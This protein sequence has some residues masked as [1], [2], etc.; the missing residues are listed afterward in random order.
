MFKGWLRRVPGEAPPASELETIRQYRLTRKLGEGG[1]GVVFEAEDERLGRLVAIKRVRAFTEDPTHRERLVREAR[2]AAGIS[3]PNI[4]QVYELGEEGEE[5]FVVMELLDG[6]TLASRVARGPLPLN[7]ALQVTLGILAALEAMHARGIVHRDLKP[8]NVFLTPHGPK[9]LDFGLAR[10]HSAEGSDLTLTSPG[11]ILGTPRYMAPEMLADEPIGPATDLFALGAILFEMLA[12]RPAF[13]GSSLPAIYNA[14][15]SEQPPPLVGDADVIAA[16]RVIQRALAKRPADRWPSAAAMAQAV[17]EALA[18]S[19]TGPTQQVR[20]VTRLIV[21][22]FRLLRPDSEIDFLASSLPEAISASLSALESVTV[23]STAAAAR[24]AADGVDLKA[25]AAD[26]G[27][28]VALLGTLLRAG[29]QVRVSIQLVEAPS[30]TVIISRVAQVALTDIFQLQDELT[31]QIVDALAIQLS[32]HDRDALRRDVPSNPESYELYLRATHLGDG[33]SN[34]NRLI[35]ARDLFRRC[36]ELDPSYAPAWARLGRVHR[37]MA[38]YGAGGMQE[39]IAAAEAAFRRALELNPELPLAHSLYTYFEIEEFGAARQ[40]MLRLLG[41]TRHGAADPELFAGLVV[42]CRFCGLLDASLEADRRARRIDPG[43]RTSVHYTYWMLGRYEQSVLSDMEDIQVLRHMG[44]WLL[45]RQAEA[46]EGV[47][48]LEEQLPTGGEWLFLTALRAAMQ[49]N[50]AEC[51]EAA[52]HVLESGFHDPEGLYLIAREL[53]YVGA[54][55]EALA[56]LE[57]VVGGGFHCPR[58][59][60]Q[61]PWLDSLRGDPAFLRL[62]HRAEEESAVSAQAFREAGGER[63]LGPAG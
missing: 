38:K 53:A 18:L 58:P 52:S 21:L 19:D 54:R 5:L 51:I 60:T 16:D 1:M 49:G 2:T 27:V 12:G 31:R 30:G 25:L 26:A 36:V 41:L 7:E 61:D 39:N 24:F 8:T 35:A 56:M 13:S 20:T 10:P 15:L 40:A 55:E 48:R 4:C 59:L 6:E 9:L 37:V 34:P 63:L 32:A 23:R 11:T 44:L 22:P 3:H 57:K 33:T 14:V 28:D 62:L 43:V 29:D 42:A 46:L 17:R 45:N 47:C 50:R